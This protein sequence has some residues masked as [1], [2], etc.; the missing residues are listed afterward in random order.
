MAGF[1]V[2]EDF[3]FLAELMGSPSVTLHERY[4]ISHEGCNLKPWEGKNYFDCY[5]HP[6]CRKVTRSTCPFLGVPLDA[7]LHGLSTIEILMCEDRI[8][9]QLGKDIFFGT[10]HRSHMVYFDNRMRQNV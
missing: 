8:R 10:L 7:F 4:G 9:K 6:E 3:R 5:N 1:G 2:H